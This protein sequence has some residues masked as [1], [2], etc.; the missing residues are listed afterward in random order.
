MRCIG[1]AKE[2][3]VR[4]DEEY[5]LW[6]HRKRGEKVSKHRHGGY[7]QADHPKPAFSV[8]FLDDHRVCRAVIAGVE[9]VF[10]LCAPGLQARA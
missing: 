6:T 10:D 5:G 8:E 3:A 1:N 2:R 9:G 7:G 4:A